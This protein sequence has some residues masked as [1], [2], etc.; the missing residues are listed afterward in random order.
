MYVKSNNQRTSLKTNS[1]ITNSVKKFCTIFGLVTGSNKSHSFPSTVLLID[2]SLRSDIVRRRSVS[3]HR[4][5]WTA[6]FLFVRFVSK[7]IHC[8]NHRAYLWYEV[9]TE[10]QS[11]N[12]VFNGPKICCFG[13]AVTQLHRLL[14]KNICST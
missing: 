4:S 11:V 7:F 12:A 3:T 9:A 1:S 6:D 5:D 10:T 8:T 14:R 2:L 13:G